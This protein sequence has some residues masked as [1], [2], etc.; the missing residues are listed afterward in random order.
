[1]AT[2]IVPIGSQLRVNQM[3]EEIW[4]L[5]LLGVAFINSYDVIVWCALR[6][7]I[8][9]SVV[10][11]ICNINKTFVKR[12]GSIDGYMWRCKSS[13]SI[14]DGSFFAGSHLALSKLIM[15]I[16]GFA[17]DFPQKLICKEEL[18]TTISNTVVDW[19]NFCRKV[20]GR[21]L[22]QHPVELGG[23]DAN[24]EPLIV[25]IDESYFFHRK[26]HRGAYRAGKWIFGAIERNSGKMFLTPVAAR[27]EETLLPIISRII[28]PGTIIITDGWRAYRNIGLLRGGVYE[29]RTVTHQT[30]FVN[31]D[32]NS[33]HTQT[34]ESVW[35]RSKK[36][37]RRQCGTSRALFQSYLHEFMWR[38]H[39][40]NKDEFVE[41][42]IC[43]SEQ[44]LV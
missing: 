9:N 24:G 35:M 22:D 1:M 40:K 27:N 6:N 18:L 17:N 28:L 2:F 25:E 10:C 20:C 16:Y 43:V 30:H 42:L 36:K 39:M 3:R 13:T 19:C 37:L 34:I 41:F 11:D 29:H 12:S 15:M 8:K 38:E 4:N 5:A 44:Y 31:P 7:L 33:A 26:Y 32:D 23:F 21:Y 14:R